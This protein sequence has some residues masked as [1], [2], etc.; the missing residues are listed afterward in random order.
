MHGQT[1]SVS[2]FLKHCCRIKFWTELRFQVIINVKNL[3][4]LIKT[5][6]HKGLQT[7][8]LAKHLFYIFSRVKI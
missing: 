7:Q 5:E 6:T 8:L 3:L 2:S 4:Y 1:A